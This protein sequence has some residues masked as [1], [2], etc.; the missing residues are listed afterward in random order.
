M[1]MKTKLLTVLLICFLAN[2]IS[3]Q[4][5]IKTADFTM[6]KAAAILKNKGYT[7]VEQSETFLK[8]K[9]KENSTLFLDIDANKKYL[10]LNTNVKLRK[11]IS[12]DK[13]AMLRNQINDLNMIKVK[14]DEKNNSLLFQYFYWI[15][16]SFTEE[17]FV[18][19]VLEFYLY[20]GDSYKLD[21]EKLFEY[22]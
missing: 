18:D 17:S 16:N 8:I 22:E 10:Y 2:L 9:N 14:Y 13:I 6:E 4:T 5:M 21:T 20:Q 3:A 7:I 1:I 19:A 12:V 11:S 15:T